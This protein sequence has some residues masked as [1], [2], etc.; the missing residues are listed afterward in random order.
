MNL[1]TEI[2]NIQQ[3]LRRIESQSRPKTTWINA[4]WVT[5]LTGWSGEK[6]RQAR[7]QG[8]IEYRRKKTGGYEYK[9]ESIPETFIIKK[10]AV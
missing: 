8:I 1:S 6:M 10:Q 4:G 7:E 9:L 5:D 2:K 3:T